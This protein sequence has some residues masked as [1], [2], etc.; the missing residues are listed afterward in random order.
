MASFRDI[1][2]YYR[3]Y[4]RSALVSIGASSFF[5]IADLTVPYAIGQ[6][7]NVLS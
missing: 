5:E 1:L 6:I 3:H 7:L 2:Q 4:W